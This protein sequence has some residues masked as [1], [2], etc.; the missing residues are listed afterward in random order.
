[1]GFLWDKGV[2]PLPALPGTDRIFDFWGQ[3]VVYSV[4]GEGAP[5]ILLHS[6]NAAAWAFDWRQNLP[7]LAESYKVYAPDLPGFGRSERRPIR[8]EALSYIEFV[9]E[10]AHLVREQTGQ[11]PAVI[12]SSLVA[13]YVISVAAAEPELFSSLLL[14]APT[15][16]QRLDFPPGQRAARANHILHGKVGD[17]LFGLLTTRFSTK[18][19][20]GRDGYYSKAKVTKDVVDG[21]WRA[22]HQPRAKF[23]PVS[24][25]TF[26]LNHSVQDE[27]P[28]VQSPVLIVW[29]KE[30]TTTPARDADRFIELRPATELHLFEATRLSLQDE[31]A[32][33]FNRVALEWL[34]KSSQE[35]PKKP[36]SSS[37]A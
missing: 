36:E 2:P 14:I 6:I 10:F 18:V 20:L 35:K 30:A 16:L 3:Q 12:A 5:V 7:A 37:A 33:D 32:A 34:A 9:R 17:I 28:K 15:G 25:I 23:A 21:Y 26:Y 27:W 8:Y 24:F 31:A 13:S 19:F 4:A 1:M 29:G 11:A 22:S